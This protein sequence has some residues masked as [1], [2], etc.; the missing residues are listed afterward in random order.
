VALGALTYNGIETYEVFYQPGMYKASPIG[1]MVVG[2]IILLI[3]FMGC[4]GVLRES[5]C[6][7]VTV[8]KCFVSF[9]DFVFVDFVS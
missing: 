5:K 8:R 2:S 1:M 7:M 6:M 3:A 9:I 4:C